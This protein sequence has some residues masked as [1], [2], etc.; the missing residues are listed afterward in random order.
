[1]IEEVE[2][3]VSEGQAEPHYYL[4]L[5]ILQ[6]ELQSLGKSVET[7]S[8]PSFSPQWNRDYGNPQTKH[9]D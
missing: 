7:Y 9:I 1:V 4:R 8:L 2:I 5:Y 6:Q 3:F